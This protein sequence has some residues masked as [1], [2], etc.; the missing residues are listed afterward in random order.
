MQGGRRM[1]ISEAYVRDL[2]KHLENGDGAA[3][4]ERVDDKAP[5][6]MNA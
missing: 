1:S 5:V 2:F 6:E 3:F 4:F